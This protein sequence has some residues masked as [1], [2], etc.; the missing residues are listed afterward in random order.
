M[1]H[2]HIATPARIGDR[3]WLDGN[4]N[5]VQDAGEAG[6]SGVTIESRMPAAR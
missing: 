2:G 6:V 1:G 3:V 5:G 4:A